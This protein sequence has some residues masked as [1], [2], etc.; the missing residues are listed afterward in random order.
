MSR[1]PVLLLT[2]IF[3]TQIASA[4]VKVKSELM[5]LR[6]RV[7]AQVTSR[8]QNVIATQLEPAT[9][10]V[11]ARVVVVEVP[12]APPAPSKNQEYERLPAGLGI[13]SIDVREIVD[14]YQREIAELKAFKESEKEKDAGPTYNISYLEVIVGLDASYSEEYQAKFSEWIAKRVEFDYGKGAVASVNKID[15]VPKLPRE[16]VAKDPWKDWL[17]LLP[18]L[19]MGLALIVA[20]W[21][22]GR[23]LRKLGEGSKNFV[24]EY[25]DAFRM[26]HK[27]DSNA[28]LDEES[29]QEIE[30]EEIS[31]TAMIDPDGTGEE[32]T[33]EEV[34]VQAATLDLVSKIVYLCNELGP[35][36]NEM[37]RVWLD[38]AGD[39]YVKTAVFMDTIVTYRER[40]KTAGPNPQDISIPLDPDLAA[41]HDVNLTEAYRQAAQM[42]PPQVLE[43]LEKIYWDLLST[44]TIGLKAMRK[45][46]DFMKVLSEQEYE[47]ALESQ[48]EQAKVVALMFADP[49]KTRL[50]LEKSSPEKREKLLQDMFRLSHLP[51]R[52]LWSLDSV[53]K[54][55]FLGESMADLSAV[56]LLPRTLE[57]MGTFSPVDQIRLLRRV[58]TGMGSTG[59]SLKTNVVSLAFVEEWKN[60]YLAKLL[61]MATTNEIVALLRVIPEAQDRVLQVSAGKQSMIIMDD[62][63][64]ANID[65]G[66]VERG[67]RMLTEKWRRYCK[68]EG[69]GMRKVLSFTNES[70]GGGEMGDAA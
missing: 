56:N 45:P 25:K 11:A 70:E 8:M 63:S 69:L 39:G 32:L 41:A 22:L 57:I 60:E 36:L 37:V 24:F 52:D 54:E 47:R 51:K 6:N 58:L 35:G 48:D 19:L 33:E 43:Y 66:R 4:Q 68:N 65:Q 23:G 38:N 64:V 18:Y 44:R 27:L 17:S 50:I 5:D 61:G 13:G 16:E 53:M 40:F 3:A 20:A 7:E 46:F 55:K 9:F 10:E 21:L 28:K 29:E 34:R 62:L 2:A 14:G 26:E 67:V 12:P 30:A 59:D 15:R 31:E 49:D 42:P 1:I